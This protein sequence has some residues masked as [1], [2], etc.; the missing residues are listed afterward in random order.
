MI[1][2][3]VN[4][5]RLVLPRFEIAVVFLICVALVEGVHLLIIW[6]GWNP[7]AGPLREAR[8]SLYA[9]A[10]LCY[11]IFRAVAFHPHVIE[12]YRRWLEN[13][14]WTPKYPLPAGPITLVPQD[15][16]VVLILMGINLDPSLR[17]FAIPVAFL[18]GYQAALAFI[19][20]DLKEWRLAYAV[21]FV[22]GTQGFFLLRP[23]LQLPIAVACYPLTWL[24]VQR[25]LGRF[26]WPR[27]Q[28]ADQ[29]AGIF[30]SKGGETALGWPY[31][32]LASKQ[33][34]EIISRHDAICLA[35]LIG[36]CELSLVWGLE[37][38][39]RPFILACFQMFLFFAP[40]GRMGAF[41]TGY[42]SPI[43]LWGRIRTGRLIIP[44]YDRI[45]IASI[46][47]WTVA[48][49]LHSM[50]L[51]AGLSGSL[52]AQLGTTTYAHLPAAWQINLAPLA[53]T[54]MLLALFLIGPGLRSWQ[55]VGKHRIVFAPQSRKEFIE[56]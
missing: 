41:M 43:D 12:D 25:T 47:A 21:G 11:G 9:I 48:M 24:A 33:P 20:W 36:W 39:T 5:M 19:H 53:T 6:K 8:L 15:L 31:D 34:Q 10:A 49:P 14:P 38:R 32:A 22:L 52:S 4:W 44:G 51:E 45:W 42:Q 54:L 50:A 27:S 18:T 16:V 40:A 46:V 35:L 26:P 30:S 56:L 13:T 7:D 29:F 37:P 17:S 3:L 55:L 1:N 23:E 28:F 2:K